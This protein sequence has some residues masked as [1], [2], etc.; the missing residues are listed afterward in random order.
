MNG[1]IDKNGSEAGFGIQDEV[2][3]YEPG[4]CFSKAVKPDG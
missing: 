3:T 4:K 2:E 1:D